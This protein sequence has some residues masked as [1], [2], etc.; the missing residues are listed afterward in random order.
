MKFKMAENSVFAILLRSSW[1]IS[2][3]VGA[4]IA[5]LCVALLPKD[6]KFV[7]A[8]G[9]L[10]FFII[11]II[12][13]KRQWK[14]PSAAQSEALLAKATMLPS[15]DL[16]A[17]LTR[18]WQA[19]GYTVIARKQADADLE[20]TRGDEITLVLT[21]RSKAAVH[22]VEPLRALYDAARQAGASSAYVLLQGELS[23]NARLFARDHNIAV[24]QNKE[25]VALLA[26]APTA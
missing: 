1:W 22:G 12:A 18:A 9:S 2:V 25:L 7:G 13:A 8:A 23:D 17:W 16:L 14:E 24:L 11:G 5:L 4:I 26:K 6:I 21:K 3:V 10:P 15:R 20:L 19:E